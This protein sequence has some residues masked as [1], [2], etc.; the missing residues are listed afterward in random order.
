MPQYKHH[1]IV[2]L[3]QKNGEIIVVNLNSIIDR[4][5]IEENHQIFSTKK[6]IKC[7]IQNAKTLISNE[8]NKMLSNQGFSNSHAETINIFEFKNQ[9]RFSAHEEKIDQLLLIKENSIILTT[10]ADK[11]MKVWSI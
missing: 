3:G 8:R 11:K 6:S 1:F 5:K 7:E 2:T 10:S 9:N 4:F